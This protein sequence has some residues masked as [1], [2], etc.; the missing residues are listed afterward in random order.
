MTGSLFEFY[1]PCQLVRYP[2][3]LTVPRCQ[4]MRTWLVPAVKK[5]GLKDVVVRVPVPDIY[6]Y[7]WR[8]R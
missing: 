3:G 2:P 5:S 1:R 7:V 4:D 6:E 8:K